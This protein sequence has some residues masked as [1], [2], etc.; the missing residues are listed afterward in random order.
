MASSVPIGADSW[1]IEKARHLL[2]RA[3]FGVPH[4]LAVRLASMTPEAAVDYLVDYESVPFDFPEPDFLVPAL[5]AKERT[6]QRKGLNEEER[7]ALQ[8]KWQREERDAV[9]KLQAWWIQRMRVSPRPLEDKMVLFWHGHFATS[10]QKVKASEH[11]Y[12]LLEVFRNQATGNFKTLVAEVGQSPCMLRYLDNDRSTK[13]QPNENWARE[14]MELFTLGQGQYTEDDIKASARAFT[15]WSMDGRTFEFRLQN[16]DTGT[17]TFLGRTGDFD[18]WDIIN[19]LCEQKALGDFIAGKLWKFFVSEEVNAEAVADLAE[20]FRMNN[21]ELKPVLRQLFLSE[22]FYAPGV[23]GTQIKSPTQ[24]VVKLTHDLALDTV[25]PV[26]LVQATARLGQDLLHPPNVKGWD[27]NRAWI[28]ANTLL[29]RYNLPVDLA[30]AATRGHNQMMAGGGDDMMMS[31]QVDPELAPPNMTMTPNEAK[32]VQDPQAALRAQV[33]E[34]LKDLP[35][36]E[37]QF[38]LKILRTG[39]PAQRRALLL[40]LGIEPP[41]TYDPLDDMFEGLTFTTAAECVQV[42][43]K[44]LIDVPVSGD[45]QQIL[46]RALGT[47]APD[48]PLAPDALG[49]D[50]RAEVLHL[51]TSMA[52]YQLC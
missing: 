29:I 24:F 4:S 36:E 28:N 22:A 15:G 35:K 20:T 13:R 47:P 3:G 26:A 31:G 37:R 8:Q 19:I 45:Q 18:G 14:L 21:Y 34:K 9:R 48:S 51:I 12:G 38:K 6:A 7:R 32:A 30:N 5:T 33:R 2:N 25:P 50:K 23:M 42:L 16:H 52:E 17:K 40:E 39:N 41:A 46:L 49:D 43:A 11:N 10:A 1:N 27:G 44:R